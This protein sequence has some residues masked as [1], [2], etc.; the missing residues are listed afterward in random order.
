MMKVAPILTCLVLLA[1]ASQEVEE[2]E[3]T[4]VGGDEF[5]R[6]SALK[7]RAVEYREQA[8]LS[9][10]P[11]ERAQWLDKANLACTRAQMEY[12]RA[13]RVYSFH[14]RE[15]IEYEMASVHKLMMVIQRERLP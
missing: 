3:R 15:Q 9:T 12:E 10:D 11:V 7:T 8:I 1:C 6:A 14:Q 4:F 13:M 2:K 5:K